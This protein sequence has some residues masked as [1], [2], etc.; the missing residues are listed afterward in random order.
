[1]PMKLEFFSESRIQLDREIKNHPELIRLLENHP[2]N[3]FE[4]RLAE[5]A[6]YCGIL[7]DGDY[8]PFELNDLCELCYWKLRQKREGTGIILPH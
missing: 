1:M 5:V 6:A 2:A 8:L 7:L 3:E 4:I